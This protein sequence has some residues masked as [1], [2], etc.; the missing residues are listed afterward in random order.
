MGRATRE[1]VKQHDADDKA[2]NGVECHNHGPTVPPA[3]IAEAAGLASV[4][5]LASSMIWAKYL[6]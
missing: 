1:C 5:G 4:A 6:W 2:P 3:A